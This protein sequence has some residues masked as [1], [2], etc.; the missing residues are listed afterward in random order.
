MRDVRFITCAPSDTYYTWQVHLWLESLRDI[1]KSDKATVLI[2]LP[3]ARP[4]NKKWDQIIALYPEAKFI[5]YREK[6]EED[7]NYLISLYIPIIREY[8]MWTYLKD[9]PEAEKEAIFFCDSD[10]LFKDNFDIEHLLDDD[11]NYISDAISYMGIVYLDNKISEVSPDKKEAFLSE[12]RAQ[13]ILNC[14]GVTRATAEANQAHSGGVQYLLKNTSVEFWAKVL[15]DSISIVLKMQELNTKFFP[16]QQLGYQSW[17]A[18][19]WGILWNMWYF[20]KEVQVVPE[21]A[22]SWA[23]CSIDRVN[24]LP[25]FHNAGIIGEIMGDH[26]CF[27]KGKYHLGSDPTAD[28]ALDEVINSFTS[29][30]YGTW[31]YAKKLKELKEKYN[32]NY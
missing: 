10:I 32:L 20:K 18:D 1:G 29:Q 31:Y 4:H 11:V 15:N 27:Y 28:P 12:D 6:P 25:I 8:L 7:I 2:Y 3:K 26:K 13:E 14:A 9:H 16:S 21:L 17:C 19:M 22:F 24:T 23:S 30:K 5:F